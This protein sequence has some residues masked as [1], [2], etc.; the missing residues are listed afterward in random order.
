MVIQERADRLASEYQYRL[1]S[2]APDT[3]HTFTAGGGGVS[4][5]RSNSVDI[6][7]FNSSEND[8]YKSW[9]RPGGMVGTRYHH[10]PPTQSSMSS[11]VG[12]YPLTAY[13]DLTG[14]GVGLDGGPLVAVGGA[15]AAPPSGYQHFVEHVYESPK[16]DRR[17]LV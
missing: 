2:S 7:S 5:L 16:F 9:G 15:G 3:E 10:G 8:Y 14:G 4:V 6:D 12:S 17:D 13:S 11:G 1:K